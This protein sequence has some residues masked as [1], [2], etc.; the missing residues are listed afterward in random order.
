LFYDYLS[1][2]A[3]FF[4]SFVFCFVQ[5]ILKQKARQDMRTKGE[6]LDSKVLF[7]RRAMKGKKNHRSLMPVNKSVLYRAARAMDGFG[8][9]GGW[10]KGQ[11][12][13]RFHQIKIMNK[14]SF[15]EPT[16][17][18]SRVFLAHRFTVAWSTMY[19]GCGPFS[20]LFLQPSQ[21]A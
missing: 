1:S 9:G 16:P 3:L 2:L 4:L 6:G 13:L 11:E 15:K 21:N 5:Q 7:L 18:D 20:L 8:W 14:F 10:K 19:A 17:E 12:H